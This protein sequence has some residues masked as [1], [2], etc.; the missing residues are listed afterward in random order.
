M[1]KLFILTAAALSWQL[2]AQTGQLPS[3]DTVGDEKTGCLADVLE[4]L[5]RLEAENA[6]EV[7]AVNEKIEK[8]SR[9]NESW[10]EPLPGS[11]SLF[12]SKLNEQ[13]KEDM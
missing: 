10:P 1:K 12:E 9:L 13:L 8:C 5:E 4:A 7:A 11:A 6:M 2:W 3:S